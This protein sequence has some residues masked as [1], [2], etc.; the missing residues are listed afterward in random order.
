M[1]EDNR[2]GLLALAIVVVAIAACI[3]VLTLD[4]C[5]LEPIWDF[6][7][8]PELGIQTTQDAM[9]WVAWNINWVDDAIHYPADEYWQSPAQTYVWR[10]GDCEDYCILALYLI[11]RDVGIKGKMCIGMCYGGLHAWVYVDGHF[12]E[13]QWGRIVDGNPEFTSPAVMLDYDE[14][15]ERATTTHK[16][17]KE[18]P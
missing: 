1:N 13:P 3:L 12:W 4:G 6:E 7:E 2:I 11:Y 16:T 14:V 5:K 17:I 18:Q 9:T 8:I 15:I 10:S